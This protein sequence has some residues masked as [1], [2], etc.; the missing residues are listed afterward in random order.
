MRSM[1]SSTSPSLPVAMYSHSHFP[2]DDAV[3]MIGPRF[4]LS[5]SLF[6]TNERGTKLLRKI[7]SEECC[8]PAQIRFAICFSTAAEIIRIHHH[9]G[10]D[11]G[12]RHRRDHGHVFVD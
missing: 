10:F 8:A 5:P 4:Q 12:P 7:I 9:R 2:D 3:E 6:T 1:G 11:F